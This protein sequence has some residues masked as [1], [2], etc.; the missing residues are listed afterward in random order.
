LEPGEENKAIYRT[1]TPAKGAKETQDS[2][3]EPTKENAPFFGKAGGQGE[4]SGEMNESQIEPIKS[5]NA[6]FS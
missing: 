6:M 4:A 1:V 5:N 3:I 2:M